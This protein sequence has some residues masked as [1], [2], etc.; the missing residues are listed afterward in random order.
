MH[1]AAFVPFLH[2]ATPADNQR[3]IK[4]DCQGQEVCAVIC[5]IGRRCEAKLAL[6]RGGAN[7]NR[8]TRIFVARI[9]PAVS[10]DAFRTHFE[11]FGTVQVWCIGVESKANHRIVFVQMQANL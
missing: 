1:A 3:L 8:T 11:H 4:V 10:E 2:P 6:P 5:T 9:L 7:P